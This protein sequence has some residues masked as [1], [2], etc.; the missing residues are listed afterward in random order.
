[1]PNYAFDPEQADSVDPE[2]AKRFY[3][4]AT[5]MAIQPGAAAPVAPAPDA[6]WMMSALAAQGRY[7]PDEG[8]ASAALW[9][10]PNETAAA[11]LRGPYNR[12]QPNSA[13][14]DTYL[15]T[16]RTPDASPVAYQTAAGPITQA[17][18][19]RGI[20]AALSV[21]GGGLKTE[22][23]KAPAILPSALP[24]ADQIG[25][26][27]QA[28]V[29]YGRKG[30][31]TAEQGIFKTTPEAYAETTALVP[32]QSI[33][34]RLPG[35][36]PG[37]G[38]PNKGR[39]DI[40]VA[41]Q[42]AIANR[43][44]ERLDP[45]VRAGDERLKFYHTGPVIRGLEQYGDMTTEGANRFMRD[46]AGQGA[47][48]SPRTQTPPNLRNSS[49]LM[50]ERA[51]G[52]PLTPER[53][54]REGNIPGFPMMGMHVDLADKFARGAENAFV[55]P[56]P[57]TFRENWSG[58][59]RDVTGD[60]HNIRSTL[61]EMDQLQPGSLPR[62][63]FNSDAAFAKYKEHGFHT[64][65]AGDIA[66]TL[67]SKTVNKIPRQS[68]Y[69]P[70]TDPWTLAAQKVGIAPAEGQSGGWFSYG[71]IT[72]LQSPPKT[73]PNLLNDQIAATAKAADVS[74]EQVVNW[75]AKGKIPLAG[76]GGITMGGLAAQNDYQPEERQ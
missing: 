34:E 25:A 44:A 42:D 37:E 53:Y 59:L 38:L 14:G 28:A 24:S 4:T 8:D 32:Q 55:N 1:M 19:D 52:D 36:L 69:L 75:W 12:T 74:P 33:R 66:D 54:A 41:N 31:P 21:S 67:G 13:F 76:V 11:R 18:V 2:I 48:T 64:V 29:G 16:A 22:I 43:I 72:G 73:I 15:T 46:W 47:A 63:W 26:I 9:R 70:M 40:I 50:Y 58:N 35:P 5:N 3:D 61:Y 68:E 56:K 39:A 65:D 45:M 62:G 20:E 6:R 57:T 60:T 10:D 49:Y 23:P 51:R 27:K 30:W 7:N 17:D 71:D